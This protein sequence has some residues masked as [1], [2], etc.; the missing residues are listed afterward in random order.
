MMAKR[1]FHLQSVF[2]VVLIL[3]S[4]LCALHGAIDKCSLS[5]N[6]SHSIVMKCADDS[7]CPT[8]NYCSSGICQCGEN[9]YGV[10]QCSNDDSKISAIL[11]CNCVTYDE[12]TGFTAI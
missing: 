2:R 5:D 12:D 7:S 1:F 4:V 8:W 9:H 10:I 11:D 3:C 6:S